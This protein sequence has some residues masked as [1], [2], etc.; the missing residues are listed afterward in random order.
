M[1]SHTGMLFHT[2]YGSASALYFEQISMHIKGELDAGAFRKTWRSLVNRHSVFRTAFIT[3][4]PGEP[5][6]VVYPY[7]ELPFMEHDKTDMSKG[8]REPWLDEYL[9]K[10]RAH[11]FAL[12]TPPL[13]RCHLIRF[14][15]TE[16]VFIWSSHHAILD[17]WCMPLVLN[18]ISGD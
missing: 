2:L 18:E 15:G 7:A 17:G 6:Q 4:G 11:G 9:K 16:H 13:M 1:A 8:F 3:E 14:S 5:L 10:D 12:D